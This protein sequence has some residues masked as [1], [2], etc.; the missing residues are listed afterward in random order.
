MP[1]DNIKD[2]IGAIIN[3]DKEDFKSSFNNELSDRVATS[4]VNKSLELSKDL[5]T[6]SDTSDTPDALE[7]AYGKKGTGSYTFKNPSDA[8]KFVKASMNAGLNKRNL[9]VNG[10]VVTVSD[11]KDTDMEEMLHFIAKDM[12]A[13]VK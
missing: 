13:T 11:L 7:E 6:S 9:K 4:V 10:K 1:E 5:L 12:K 8:K 3:G 2:M